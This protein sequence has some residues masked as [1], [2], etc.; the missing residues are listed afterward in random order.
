MVKIIILF[1]FAGTKVNFAKIY[2]W[3]RRKACR[4]DTNFASQGPWSDTYCEDWMFM[5][6]LSEMVIEYINSTDDKNITV[7]NKYDKSMFWL[8]YLI[9]KSK[10]KHTH[11]GSK[12]YQS[13][14]A[15]NEEQNRCK[16]DCAKWKYYIVPW[17]VA[18][19]FVR[20]KFRGLLFLFILSICCWQYIHTFNVIII[21]WNEVQTNNV[22]YFVTVLCIVITFQ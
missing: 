8:W 10:S 17:V 13:V 7:S 9:T 22:W 18:S 20:R 2:I 1:Y 5:L 15:G 14:V 12:C 21:C 19:L 4:A 16:T 6:P 11:I 3:Q